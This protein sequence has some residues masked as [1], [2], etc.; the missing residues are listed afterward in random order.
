MEFLFNQKL[1]HNI[2]H[3][4][5]HFPMA[6]GDES[7]PKMVASEVVSRGQCLL[8]IPTHIF[9]DK[10]SFHVL[11]TVCCFLVFEFE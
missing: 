10:L 1:S 7:I 3:G 9:I 6:V 11:Y 2:L 8:H 4:L 5:E